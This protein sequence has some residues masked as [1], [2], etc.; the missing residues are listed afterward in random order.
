MRQINQHSSFVISGGNARA[1]WPDPWQMALIGLC[2][3]VLCSCRSPGGA[4]NAMAPEGSAR[5]LY[6][7]PGGSATL[8]AEAYAGAA[9]Q[10]HK[11]PGCPGDCPEGP[12]A[13]PTGCPA[14]GPWSPPGIRQPWPE[15]E[16]LC[17]GG[18]QGKPV[19][20]NGKKEILGLK[21]E[22]TVAHFDTLDGRTVVEP[23]NEVCLYSPRFGAVRQVVSLRADEERQQ[24]AGVH[25]PQK[26]DIPTTLQIPAGA[27][28][29]LQAG[30]QIAAR[31]PVAMRS[32]QGDGVMSSAVGPRGFQ[33]AF[34]AYENMAII[35]LGM[36]EESE[37]PFLARG[38]TAAIAWSHTQ[39][40]QVI[41]DKR[42][43]MAEV[44][45]DAA[46]SVYTVTTP[47]GNPRLRLCKVASTATAKP[48]EEVDFTIRFDNVGDQAIGN[49]TIL[50]SLSTRLEFVPGSAQC[51]LEAKFTTQPN[52]GGSAIV[53]CEIAK[54]LN[55]GEGGILR[56]RCRV[57]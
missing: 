17:D 9:S 13:C 33:N 37:M 32:K 23:S 27:K 35:R 47:P 5:N 36:F 19:G 52:E 54:P 53:R 4:Q 43:A 49:V 11:F 26:L 21:M 44:K 24:L 56:F 28:Q 14:Q 10:W 51:N 25:N 8:P 1:A 34:K 45:Y 12:A 16:Y 31:P 57:R 40:V 20:I 42:G 41:L 3:L 2:A 55:V 39:A 29:H 48:G 22:D 6:Q 38:A 30:D 50:D 18:D 7:G 46:E 15:D